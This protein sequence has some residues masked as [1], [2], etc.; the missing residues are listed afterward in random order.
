[1]NDKINTVCGITAKIKNNVILYVTLYVTINIVMK[2]KSQSSVWMY[3]KTMVFSIVTDWNI[4]TIWIIVITIINY[5][6]ISIL[7][8]LQKKKKIKPIIHCSKK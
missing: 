7:I 1:M 5:N 3:S 2:T 6:T 8:Q 4:T